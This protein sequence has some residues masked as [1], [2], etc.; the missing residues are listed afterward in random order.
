MWK[1]VNLCQPDA[2]GRS[3]KSEGRNE[4]EEDSLALTDSRVWGE[5]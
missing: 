2:S 1:N 5:L 4:G 3:A